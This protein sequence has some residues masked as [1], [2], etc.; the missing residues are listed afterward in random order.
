[1]SLIG[2]GDLGTLG[3]SDIGFCDLL[4]SCPEPS[5]S[6]TWKGQHQKNSL[7]SDF[8]IT[9]KPELPKIKVFEGG[10]SEMQLKARNKS[11]ILFIIIKNKRNTIMG[12]IFAEQTILQYFILFCMG[13]IFSVE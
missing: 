13:F 5:G 10:S 7:H 3:G 11:G 12:L 8:I 1:M 6:N 4:T 2:G 9:Q